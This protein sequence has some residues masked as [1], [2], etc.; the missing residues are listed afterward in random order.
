[1]YRNLVS[2]ERHPVIK[3]I[4]GRKLFES[5]EPGRALGEGRYGAGNHATLLELLHQEQKKGAETDERVAELEN[6]VLECS[7]G[8]SLRVKNALVEVVEVAIF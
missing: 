5:E 1:L 6:E 8:C 7:T 2:K 4:K 3:L